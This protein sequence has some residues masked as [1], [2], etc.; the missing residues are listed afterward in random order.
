MKISYFIDQSKKMNISDFID[1]KINIKG[2]INTIRNQYNIFLMY[3]NLILKIIIVLVILIV[4]SL[5]LVGVILI[6][7]NLMLVIMDKNYL[8]FIIFLLLLTNTM[9]SFIRD[10][11]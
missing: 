2:W 11:D 3:M 10:G 8:I 9:E 6:V 7:V 5:I 1:Q 4:M